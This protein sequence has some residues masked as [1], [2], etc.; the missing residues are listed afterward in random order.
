M[1]TMTASLT[2]GMLIGTAALAS[3]QGQF[4]TVLSGYDEAPALATAA[5]GEVSVEVT[6]DRSAL[7]VTLTFSGLEGVAQSAG[8]YFGKPALNGGL[9]AIVCGAP[10]PACPIGADATVTASVGANDVLAIPSQGLA[11]ADLDA[12]VRALENG[13]VYVNVLSTKY[14]AGEMRGQLERGFGK[15]GKSK[16]NGR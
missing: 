15:R 7:N 9:A 11:A 13:A 3:A 6:K 8:L 5:S 12:L 1:T 2:V 16:N 4:K 14:P 10:K